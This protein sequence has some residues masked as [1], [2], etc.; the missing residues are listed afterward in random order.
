MI[1]GILTSKPLATGEVQ[2]IIK[3]TKEA[4]PEL[5]KLYGQEVSI[6]RHI[7]DRAIVQTPAE[8]ILRNLLTDI[9][10]ARVKAESDIFGM[11]LKKEKEEMSGSIETHTDDRG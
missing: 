2:I 6:S 1:T 3:A 5:A 11:N 10:V 4:I 8:V 9:D 7:E